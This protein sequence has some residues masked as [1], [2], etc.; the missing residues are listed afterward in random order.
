MSHT[1]KVCI[2]VLQHTEPIS[3][4]DQLTLLPEKANILL[5]T[6]TAEETEEKI[7]Q[8]KKFNHKSASVCFL[9]NYL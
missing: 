9:Y 6:T 4:A 1:K 2:K 7:G 5:M 8:W 3:K